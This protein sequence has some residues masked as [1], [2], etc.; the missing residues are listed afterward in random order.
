MLVWLP[1]E[2]VL[3]SH[4]L[5]FSIAEKSTLMPS[6]WRKKMVDALLPTV[7]NVRSPS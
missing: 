7:D 4:T 5:P 2:T 1:T 6:I 3:T